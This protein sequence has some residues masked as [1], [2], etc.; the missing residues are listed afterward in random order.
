MAWIC[1]FPLLGHIW[2]KFG[3]VWILGKKIFKKLKI[4]QWRSSSCIEKLAHLIRN[5]IPLANLMEF[6]EFNSVGTNGTFCQ[7]IISGHQSV[8]S[9]NTHQPFE[10]E[11]TWWNLLRFSRVS[12]RSWKGTK[13]SNNCMRQIFIKQIRLVKSHPLWWPSSF[14]PQW[15]LGCA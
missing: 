4:T 6:Q 2:V 5:Y 15:Q 10:Y 13:W 3:S 1:S 8:L 11:S 9:S 7:E 14:S 12:L